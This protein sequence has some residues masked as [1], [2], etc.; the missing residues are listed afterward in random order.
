M[1]IETLKAQIDASPVSTRA[2]YQRMFLFAAPAGEIDEALAPIL[3]ASSTYREFF[4]GIVAQSPDRMS[5]L[6]AECAR[7]SN[8]NWLRFFEPALCITNVRMK[9]DGIPVQLGSG[10]M[11]A[12]TGSR[13]NIAT[14]YLFNQGDFNAQAADFVT[15]IGGTFTML[16]Y[17]FCGIYGV[18]KSHGSVIF[19]TWEEEHAPKKVESTENGRQGQQP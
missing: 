2:D 7:R 19:E 10:V 5:L 1:D 12:P 11:L 13:D 15:S 17:E 9:T 3:D 14:F 4:N 6:W 8:R 16:D 18:Y